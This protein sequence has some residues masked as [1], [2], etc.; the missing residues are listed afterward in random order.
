MAKRRT[1]ISNGRE[2]RLRIYWARIIASLGVGLGCALG[3]I[4]VF[5]QYTG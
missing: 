2:V 5:Y 3:I 1:Y 4:W